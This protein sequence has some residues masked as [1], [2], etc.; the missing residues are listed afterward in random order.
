MGVRIRCNNYSRNRRAKPGLFCYYEDAAL[1]G[2]FKGRLGLTVNVRY[3]HDSKYLKKMFR[4]QYSRQA[5]K[6]E[7]IV[8]YDILN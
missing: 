7:K 3:L 4:K 6:R 5:R 1:S 2:K 8:L